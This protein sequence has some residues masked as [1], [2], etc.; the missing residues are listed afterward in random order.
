MLKRKPQKNHRKRKIELITFW[1]RDLACTPQNST[2]VI[3]PPTD[4]KS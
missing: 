2:L 1:L 4:P 3:R